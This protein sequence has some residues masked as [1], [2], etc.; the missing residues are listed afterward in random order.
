MRIK[1][2]V[3]LSLFIISISCN[4]AGNTEQTQPIE[5][6]SPE[7]LDKPQSES[8]RGEIK[9]NIS[10][11]WGMKSYRG[12]N[13]INQLFKEAI[14]KNTALRDLVSQIEEIKNSKSDSTNTTKTFLGNN[15]NYYKEV[16]K[17]LNNLEDTILQKRV[18]SIFEQS[19]NTFNTNVRNQRK[20]LKLILEKSKTLEQQFS[21]MKLYI[22][23]AMMKNYQK[24]N[25]PDTKPLE[26]LI[27]NYDILIKETKTYIK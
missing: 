27:E 5:E 2:L 7:I 3:V 8:I 13:I 24:E 23:D 9:N 19:E 20:G 25:L 14:E 15:E 21:L 10:S 18:R 17:Y 12:G 4:D 26:D 11:N 22:A 1:H 16:D 6:I